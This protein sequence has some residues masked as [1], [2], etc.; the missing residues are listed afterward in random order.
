EIF[1]FNVPEGKNDP[2]FLQNLQQEALNYINQQQVP[3]LEKHKAE[4]LKVAAK[5]RAAYN[6]GYY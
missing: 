4:E 5:E 1:P 6:A 3:N 2:A